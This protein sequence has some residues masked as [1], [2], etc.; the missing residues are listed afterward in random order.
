MYKRIRDDYSETS[1]GI[2]FIVTGSVLLLLFS[3]E[4]FNGYQNK[5][6]G[7]VIEIGS[8]GVLGTFRPLKT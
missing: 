8:F 2:F 6:T 3:L 7:G 1:D 5:A 4:V